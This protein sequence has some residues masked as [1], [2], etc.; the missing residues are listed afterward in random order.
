MKLYKYDTINRISQQHKLTQEETDLIYVLSDRVINLDEL[1]SSI[2]ITQDET[3]KLI[4][5]TCKKINIKNRVELMAYILNV[6]H[7][8]MKNDPN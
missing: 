1:A 3:E 8:D 4:E 2:G 6:L 7:S 5:S